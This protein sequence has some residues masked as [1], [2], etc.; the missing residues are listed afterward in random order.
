M[1][2]EYRQLYE[3]MLFEM[4]DCGKRY[5]T[6][7]EQIECCFQTCER[8]WNALLKLFN[9]RQFRTV[10]D[11][12]W[13]FKTV[14][15]AFTGL[16]EYFALVY[17]AALFHP[18]TG[19]DLQDIHNFWRKELHQAEKFLSENEQL[20]HYYKTGRTEMDE[21]YFRR[22]AQSGDPSGQPIHRNHYS[23]AFFQNNSS[24]DGIF[25]AILARDKYLGYVKRKIEMVEAQ[26]V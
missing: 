21:V 15:P 22:S 24:H 9:H 1:K 17:K 10:S 11:E 14:K 8:N 19:S 16:L 7:K 18:E 20:Y 5:A 3:K 13:F 25:A 2:E 23:G 12:I 6:E 26:L 4:E